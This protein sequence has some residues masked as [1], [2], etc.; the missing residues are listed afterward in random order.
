MIL[1][2]FS[3]LSLHFL[4]FMDLSSPAFISPLFFIL[5]SCCVTWILHAGLCPL[6]SSVPCQLDFQFW[7]PWTSFSGLTSLH[8][9]LASGFNWTLA[10]LT[11]GF[12]PRHPNMPLRHLNMPLRHVNMQLPHLNPPCKYSTS[13]CEFA[14]SLDIHFITL[15]ILTSGLPLSSF[16]LS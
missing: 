1:Y 5:W 3:L 10:S 15:C 16:S 8:L 11:S 13:I 2:W 6:I 7:T 4:Q 12:W 9:H 14:N